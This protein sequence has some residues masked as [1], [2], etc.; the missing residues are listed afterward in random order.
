MKERKALRRIE[1]LVRDNGALFLDGIG[2][3]IL[4]IIDEGLR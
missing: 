1:M 4:D 3:E 2:A